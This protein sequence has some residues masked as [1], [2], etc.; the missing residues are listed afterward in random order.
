MTSRKNKKLWEWI[1]K[2]FSPKKQKKKV[3]WLRFYE[4]KLEDNITIEQFKIFN[5]KFS[6]EIQKMNERLE[7]IEKEIETLTAKAE[8]KNNRDEIL[9]KYAKVEELNR[10]IIDEFIESIHIGSLNKDKHREITINFKI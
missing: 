5:K 8:K 2:K 9:K 10:Q 4:D 6:F 3:I 1:R 7:F